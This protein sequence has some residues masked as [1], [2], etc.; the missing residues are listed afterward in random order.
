VRTTLNI[1][2]DVLQAAKELA[3]RRGT[4]IGTT[5]SELVRKGLLGAVLSEPTIIRNGVPVLPPRNEVITLEHI[6]GIM[7]IEA[8]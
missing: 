4:S 5:I 7:N 1:D 6:Q 3:R 2:D 8:V